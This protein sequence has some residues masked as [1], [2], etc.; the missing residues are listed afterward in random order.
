MDGGNAL[1]PTT[2]RGTKVKAGTTIETLRD[3]P[4]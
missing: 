3:T 4:A 2:K 1:V